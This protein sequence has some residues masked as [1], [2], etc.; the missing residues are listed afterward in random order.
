MDVHQFATS[1][2]YGD[3]I[4]DEML[5]IQSVLREHGFGSEIFVRQFDPRSAAAVRDYREYPRWSKP[6][7]VVIFHFS[8]GSPVSKMF[9]RIP[10]RKMM[11]YHNITPAGFFLDSHRILTRECY[12]GRL[13][14]N[15]FVD[16]VD[17][18]L[19]DSD[20][21]RREL[22]SVGYKKTGVLPIL[23]NFR[24]FDGPG[25]PVVR[26]LY[27][28][29]K[30]TILYVG[31][32]IPNKKFEDVVKAFAFYKKHFNPEA[33]LILAGD[34]R[35]Q[36]RYLAGLQD[37]I[38]KL[39][40]ADVHLTGHVEFPEL[41]AYYRLADYYLSMS[42]HEGFGVPLLEAFHLGIPVVAFAAGAVEE[43]MNGGGVVLRRKD[44]LRTAGLIDEIE[45]R[46]ELRRKIVEGQKKALKPYLRENVSRVLLAQ[47]A[48]AAGR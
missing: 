2:T 3:A 39:R 21:N 9:L 22:A 10:D 23:M 1:L 26:G 34:Y 6:E 12:K 36:D 45:R 43:T 33:R 41:L 31:R 18:A 42:E 7:N 17:L 27:E 20:F 40:I 29:K 46:P 5:E 44:P 11:I 47:I 38:A 8:I 19:G 24:K 15:M 37:L 16:K 28:T 35:G 14:I 48:E 4:S 32:V 13:E 25:D 30:T